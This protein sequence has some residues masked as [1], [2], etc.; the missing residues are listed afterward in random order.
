MHRLT[1]THGMHRLRESGLA[2]DLVDDLDER[3]LTIDE[4]HQLC[5]M[6]FVGGEGAGL[7]NPNL[8]WS[9]FLQSLGGL[10]EK[11]KPQW[12]SVK[13]CF[14]PWIDTRK[15][16]EYETPM[17]QSSSRWRMGTS[18]AREPEEVGGRSASQRYNRPEKD[19]DYRRSKS[20]SNVAPGRPQRDPPART[21]RE[22]SARMQ[23]EPSASSR[24]ATRPV[25]RSGVTLSDRL[26]SWSHPSKDAKKPFS[27]DKL[28]V[29]VPL[30]FP[31]DNA[32]VEDHP[33]FTKWK[34]IDE[35]AFKNIDEALLKGLLKRGANLTSNMCFL[36]SC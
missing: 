8:S 35:D 13:N 17:A 15:L 19:S 27:V 32:L 28:L 26:K 29:T 1:Y 25:N 24:R 30:L 22:P 21:Q 34:A 7:P 9:A 16:K 31:P 6:M 23:R 20:D 3:Q 5:N 10:M 11:E 12:N 18:A 2:P 33:Y 4:I 14:T 36:G